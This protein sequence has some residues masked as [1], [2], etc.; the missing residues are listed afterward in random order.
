MAASSEVVDVT[1]FG[2]VGDGKTDDTES[3]QTAI[4]SMADRGGTLLFPKGTYVVTSVGIRPGIRYLGY[5]ATIK[6][7]ANKLPA[8]Q[9]EWVR[10]F[11]ANKRGYL[12][13]S[14]KDS[15]P[16]T[17]EGFTFD[18]NFT[19]QGPYEGYELEHACL[20]FLVAD[21]QKAGRLRASVRNCTFQNCVADGLSVYTNVELQVS[22]CTAVDCFRGGLTITGGYSVIQV[23]QFISKGK[24]HPTGIDV[25]V[26]GAGFGNTR[27][28]ELTISGMTLSDGDFDIGVNDESVVLVNNVIAKAPFYIYGGGT[29]LLKISDSVFG[30]GEYSSKSNRIVRPGNL[31]FHNCT[32]YVDGTSDAT[33]REWAC[34]HIYWNLGD[35]LLFK[36]QSVQF[37]DCEFRVGK[38]IAS[39]DTTYAVYTEAD[40]VEYNNRLMISGGTIETDFDFGVYLNRGGNTTLRNVS[41]N[42]DTGLSLGSQNK[43]L[44]DVLIDDVDFRGSRAYAH[45]NTH[46]TGNK[47]TH[48]NFSISADRNIITTRYGIDKNTYLGGRMILGEN[49]PTAET[50]GLVNDIYRQKQPQSGATYEWICTRSGIGQGAIWKPLK[51]IGDMTMPLTHAMW[52]HGH[53]MTIEYPDRVS[54]LERRGY[55]IRVRGNQ[56]SWNWFHFAI[57]TPV[58]VDNSRLRVGSILLRFRTGGG[59]SLKAVH[60]WDGENRILMDDT[61]DPSTS[62]DFQILRFSVPGNPEVYWGLGISLKVEYGESSGFT[63]AERPLMFDISSAGCDFLS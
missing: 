14:D 46:A 56:F 55:Y 39:R 43:H 1:S 59:T 53:S 41:I 33:Q 34:A 15:A 3:I 5:G 35:E 2:A 9:A 23:V 19:E 22:N 12:F 36:N 49:P 48:R 31:T 45:I 26:D 21:P 20:I 40:R 11:D 47:L 37:L 32:F 58:I 57:P 50:H 29:S 18:G 27:K 62:E 63:D 25:E 30:V 6:R 7:P 60:V 52:T 8:E 44:F 61:V 54:M 13:S 17:I 4:D 10:T 42:S 38:E 24:T 28:I 51:V 16:L